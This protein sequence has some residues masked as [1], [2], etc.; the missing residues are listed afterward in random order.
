MEAQGLYKSG[1]L[2]KIE[3]PTPENLYVREVVYI[4][5]LL[6]STRNV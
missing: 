2:T 1:A 3:I 4:E 6:Q 5:V